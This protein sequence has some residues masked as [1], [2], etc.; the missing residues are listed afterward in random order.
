M[1]KKLPSTRN[2]RSISLV[3]F[4]IA[5]LIFSGFVIFSNE[6]SQSA[7]DYQELRRP[8]T[9]DQVDQFE[10]VTVEVLSGG[11]LT[12]EGSSSQESFELMQER[13]EEINIQLSW[14]DDIGS[15]DKFRLSLIRDDEVL[16]MNEGDTGSITISI[17]DPLGG[18][19]GSFIVLI[20]AIDCPGVVNGAPIDRDNGN[21]WQIFAD[22]KV[23]TFAGVE[24]GR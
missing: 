24:N 5:A 2:D 22:A 8:L 6:D 9:E 3:Y 11:G 13:V 7:Q 14:T 21:D 17:S 4:I 12:T 1:K 16:R 10:I 18:L 20:E 15:N 23:S 19:N